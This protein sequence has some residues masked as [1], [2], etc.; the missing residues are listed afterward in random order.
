MFLYTKPTQ[1]YLGAN[2]KV[3]TA[4]ETKQIM[5][6]TNISTTVTKPAAERFDYDRFAKAIPAAG[7]HINIDKDGITEWTETRLARTKY[8]DRRYSSKK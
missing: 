7:L 4:A 5:H 3:Y 6:N 2:D 8:M 1:T